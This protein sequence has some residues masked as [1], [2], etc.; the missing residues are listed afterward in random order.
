MAI[1]ELEKMW[2]DFNLVKIENG[3]LKQP[4]YNWKAGTEVI[5][6]LDWFNSNISDLF[7]CN[8]FSK[9][10]L[11]IIWLAFGDI[12]INNDDEIE[13]YFY[14]W[15]KGT[16]RFDIWHWFDEKLPNGLAVDFNLV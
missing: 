14:C 9:V 13:T 16:Y 3:T 1:T 2:E 6:I 15:E 10:L 8:R 4:F 7:Y 12:P 11:E 5:N